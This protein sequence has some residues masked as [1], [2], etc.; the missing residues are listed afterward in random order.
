MFNVQPNSLFK[1]VT[2]MLAARFSTRFQQRL[3]GEFRCIH[4]IFSPTAHWVR[5]FLVFC[6][7][8]S[9]L[10]SFNVASASVLRG[11]RCG[12]HLRTLH[13]VSFLRRRRC[14][15]YCINTQWRLATSLF[16]M[17]YTAR[18]CASRFLLL[19]KISDRGQKPLTLCAQ[20]R[21]KPPVI[22][23]KKLFTAKSKDLALGLDIL[24]AS[25]QYCNIGKPLPI[26][27]YC[28][29]TCKIAKTNT[30]H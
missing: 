7:L 1:I 26:L 23:F 13:I 29:E 24:Q 19:L 20:R 11:F 14:H 18:T 22:L 6:C 30:K 8:I 21:R 28:T 2:R 10:V 25:V 27:L 15:K 4:I 12:C 3:A 5:E 9:W 16:I 17:T